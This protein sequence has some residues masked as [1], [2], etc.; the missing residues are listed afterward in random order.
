MRVVVAEDGD[1]I[2]AG[3]LALLEG[4][5]DV[6]VVG[7]AADLP[8]LLAAVEAHAPDVV[9]TDVRMPP[10]HGDEGIRAARTLRRSH[11]DLGVLVL[12]QYADAQYA[13]DL[14][15]DGSDGR[16]YLLKERVGD[17][18]QLVESLRTVAAGGSV[19]DE[20]VVE[21]LVSAGRKRPG[22]PLSRLTP[23]ELEVLGLVAG[24]LS[25]QAIAEQLVVTDRAVEKHVSSV[26]TKLELPQDT[27]THRRVAAALVYLSEIGA[28]SRAA[29]P[30]PRR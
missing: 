20:T 21:M 2:R 16:G 18:A 30:G 17:A 1:L 7:V 11:P 23:R 9:L 24:G 4:F 15:D 14:V 6:E 28:P 25:N 19:V 29:T 13:L 26:L 8:G 3:L 10:G 5:E 12:T 22:S 27:Q